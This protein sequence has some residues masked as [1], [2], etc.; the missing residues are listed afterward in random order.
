[1]DAV[2]QPE[3]VPDVRDVCF[4]GVLADVQGSGD[5]GVGLAGGYQGEYLEFA[6]GEHAGW[7]ADADGAAAGEL[8]DQPAGDARGQQRVPGAIWSSPGAGSVWAAHRHGAGPRAGPPSSPG[9][10][11]APKQVIT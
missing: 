3:F 10:A 4:H 9:P 6:G 1:M 7:L 5:L 2:T 8:G 11:A